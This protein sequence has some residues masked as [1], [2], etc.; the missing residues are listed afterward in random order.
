MAHGHRVNTWCACITHTDWTPDDDGSHGPRRGGR[1][2]SQARRAAARICTV[3]RLSELAGG[4]LCFIYRVSPKRVIYRDGQSEA[5]YLPGG[6]SEAAL[7]VI[8]DEK[9]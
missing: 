4:R 7:T 5:R 3:P 2:V 9:Q 6:Q 1:G 8:Y